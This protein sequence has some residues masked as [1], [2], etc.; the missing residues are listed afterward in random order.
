MVFITTRLKFKDMAQYPLVKREPVSASCNRRPNEGL[1]TPKYSLYPKESQT[2]CPLRRRFSDGLG[3]IS[4]DCKLDLITIQCNLT[5]DQYIRDVLQPVVVPHFDTHP[6]ATRPVYMDDNGRPHRS[7]AITAYLQSE[8]VTYVPWPAMNPDWNPIEHIW[9]MLGRRIQAWKPLVQ[10]IRQLEAALHREW[11]P[12]SQQ[13]IRRQTGEMRRMVETVI[14][15][16]R[17]YT[18]YSTLNNTCRQV[19]HK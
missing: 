19:I 6:L 12:L 9:D 4:H 15:E 5:G 1:E 13:Y 14:Q 3:C 10:N 18:R 11:K 8:A 16:R 17:G 7:R 2:N